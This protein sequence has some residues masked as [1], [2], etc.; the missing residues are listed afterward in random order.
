MFLTFEMR[1]LSLPITVS[2]AK[3]IKKVGSSAW[4]HQTSDNC[5]TLVGN[6]VMA[7]SV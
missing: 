3:A 4:I 7:L 2:A 1:M 5:T 6:R